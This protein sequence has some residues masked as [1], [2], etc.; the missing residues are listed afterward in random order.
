MTV[1]QTTL[2]RKTVVLVKEIDSDTGTILYSCPAHCYSF[3]TA[4][5]IS[6]YLYEV[7]LKHGTL[8]LLCKYFNKY[9][10]RIIQIIDKSNDEKMNKP[11]HNYPHISIIIGGILNKTN[12]I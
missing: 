2:P 10:D 7:E 3:C 6:R 5:D 9:P 4:Q 1:T 8:D 11:N 12:N